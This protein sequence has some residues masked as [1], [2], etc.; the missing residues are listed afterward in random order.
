MQKNVGTLDRRLRLGV[1]L[2]LAGTALFANLVSPLPL[3]LWIGALLMLVTGGA[4]VCPLYGVCSIS[5]RS[6]NDT[7]GTNS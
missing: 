1:S 5:T 3:I 7:K 4:A 6:P 2:A